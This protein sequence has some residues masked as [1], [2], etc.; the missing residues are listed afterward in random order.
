M[1]SSPLAKTQRAATSPAAQPRRL[2]VSGAPGVASFL[3]PPVMVLLSIVSTQ[4]GGATAKALLATHTSF[5]L[6][7]LR[8]GFAAVVL[9]VLAPPRLRQCSRSQWFSAAWLGLA[10]ATLSL[11]F[12]QSIS[13]TPLG[14]T[15]T[16]EFLGPLTV[17][18]LG[19]RK[20]R[21]LIWPVLALA[22]IL[23]LAPVGNLKSLSW[24][25][26]GFAFLGAAAWGTYLILAKQTTTLFF[27]A[28]GL[29]LAM[30]FAAISIL[31][32]GLFSSGK[33]L[34]DVSLLAN[35]LWLSLLSTI[36][37]LSLEFLALKQM[38]S[39]TLGIL[40]SGEPAVAA[41][42]GL[43]VLHEHLGWQAWAALALVSIAVFGVM[44]RDAKNYQTLPSTVPQ[45]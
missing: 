10:I 35:G 17:A 12:Y 15:M 14:I 27:G 9:W 45:L 42:I 18:L 28:T 11:A 19:S 26:L 16:I 25:G 5:S 2:S 40:M 30:T 3:P 20:T 37:P 21:D 34:L 6:V 43:I 24:V 23:L 29:T 44:S 8:T 22:G 1:S 38:S 41:L 39:G 36:I 7:L 31:P 32:V 4:L 13:R 33:S